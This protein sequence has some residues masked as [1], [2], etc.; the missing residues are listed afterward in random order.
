MACGLMVL[1]GACSKDEVA[2][3]NRD[4]DEITF[5]VVANSASRATDVFCNNNNPGTFT[6]SAA[7]GG[8]SYINGDDFAYVNNKWVNQDGVRYWPEEDNVDFYAHVNGGQAYKWSVQNKTASAKFED[9]TVNQKVAEQVDLLYAVKLEQ[10]KPESES[11]VTLNFRHALSQVVFQAKNTN[12]N[13]YV[14]ITGVEVC[15]LGEKN[16]FTF[17]SESTDINIVDHQG[18]TTSVPSEAKGWGTWDDL[19]GGNVDYGVTFEAAKVKGNSEVVALT[20][21]DDSEKQGE[22]NSNT[23]LL[24]P[25]KTTPWDPETN[26]TPGAGEN[27]GSYFLVNCVIFNVAGGSGEADEND[28]CIWGDKTEEGAWVPAKVAIPVDIDW[29]QGRKYIYTFVFGNGNGGYDP[30]PGPDDPDPKPVLIPI[31][32]EIT[33]DDFVTVPAGDIEMETEEEE[34]TSEG[35]EQGN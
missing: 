6:V 24:L 13:M 20:T 31:T 3:V 10:T 7:S 33:V 17:P 35:G 34:T 27:T 32:F 23:M 5:N 25:Q 8:V 22:Y 15:N 14:E 18:S 26:P 19:T 30:E 28:K 16:T 21:T 1:L 2:E 12:K 9:F 11:P 29:E 4:G